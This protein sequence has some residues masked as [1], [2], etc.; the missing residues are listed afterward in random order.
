M[1]EWYR[2]CDKMDDELI[3]LSIDV[4]EEGESTLEL[5]EIWNKVKAVGDAM[6]ERIKSLNKGFGDAMRGWDE[7]IDAL[8]EDEEKLEA[9]RGIV[10]R[11]R[12]TPVPKY[13]DAHSLDEI[14]GV[15]GVRKEMQKE[16]KQ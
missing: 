15:L 11:K 6:Q 9:I 10:G 13:D 3:D 1:T 16:E 14:R 2:L 4:A 8:N 12:S 7:T 5:V